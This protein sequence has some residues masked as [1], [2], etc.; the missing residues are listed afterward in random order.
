M[1]LE[2]LME[3]IFAAR[4]HGDWIA[5]L[6]AAKLPYGKVNSIA[7]VLSHPQVQAR[8]M[9]REM[10]SPVGRVPV[11]ASPLRLSESPERLDAIP[12]LG[13]DTEAILREL[14]YSDADIDAMRKD[15][16]I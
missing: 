1:A 13:D 8:G 9:V 2:K 14:S 4:P 7:E 10:D 16:V 11:I 6:A 5:R 15:G 3:E 12:G